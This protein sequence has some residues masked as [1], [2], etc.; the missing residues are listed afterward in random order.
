M[1]YRRFL[2]VAIAWLIVFLIIAVALVIHADASEPDNLIAQV[3]YEEARGEPFLGQVAVAE[4][5]LNRLQAPWWAD[6]V[7]EVIY[8]DNQF[9]LP[10]GKSNASTEAATGTALNSSNVVQGAQYFFNPDICSPSWVDNL[11]YVCNIGGHAFYRRPTRDEATGR[12][13]SS[14]VLRFGCHGADVEAI[15][16]RLDKLGYSVEIDGAFGAET[17]AAVMAFQGDHGLQDDGIV[18]PQTVA[19]MELEV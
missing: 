15:Q 2:I 6:T 17:E 4:V 12:G 1:I 13:E 9:A 5:I 19:A 16:E 18:G 3:V 8:Q 10:R 11:E 7:K 14:R